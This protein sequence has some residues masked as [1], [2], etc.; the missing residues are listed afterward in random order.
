MGSN[1]YVT[2]SIDGGSVSRASGEGRAVTCLPW[3]VTPTLG[4]SYMLEMTAVVADGETV[5]LGYFGDVSEFG[6]AEGLAGGLGQLVLGITRSGETLEWEV[7]WQDHGVRS[8]TT[9]AAIADVAVDEEVRLQ[10]GWEDLFASG[11]DL[12]DAWLDT[13][14]GTTHLA[15]GNMTDEIDVFGAGFELF[16]GTGS[17][18]TGFA[19]AVPEPGS[20]LMSVLGMFWLAGLRRQ[21]S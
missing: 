8:T 13:S 4:D 2:T 5:S 7:S 17:R 11:N 14:A 21:R 6:T 16:G 10:L 19:A 12:F 1:D 15:A 18:I 9:G 20:L 3:R